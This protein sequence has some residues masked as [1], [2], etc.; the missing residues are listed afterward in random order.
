MPRKDQNQPSVVVGVS[1]VWHS[2]LIDVK[3]LY[4]Y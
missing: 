1:K 2:V 3:D 4:Y